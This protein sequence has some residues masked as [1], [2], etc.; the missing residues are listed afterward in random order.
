VR[1]RLLVR[2]ILFVV[3]VVFCVFGRSLVM[4]G[5]K[6]GVGLVGEC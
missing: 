5:D 3:V 4:I 1:I 2:L 6:V